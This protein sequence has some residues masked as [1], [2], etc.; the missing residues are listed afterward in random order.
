LPIQALA[1]DEDGKAPPL[2]L[3]PAGEKKAEP[4]QP[5]A[6]DKIGKRTAAEHKT[7]DIFKGKSWYVAPPKPKPVPPPP[8]P[9]P[10]PP[11]APPLPYSFMG[12]YQGKDGKMIIYLTRGDQVYAVSPG[13]VLESIYRVQGISAGQLILI[14]LPLNIQQTI[15]IGGTS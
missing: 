11:T 6:L 3:K 9:P 10:P 2:I 15:S 13:D 5:A 12:T 14:Y 7:V 4:E 8:P 1:Q